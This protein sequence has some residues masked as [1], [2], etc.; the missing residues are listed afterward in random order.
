MR[1]TFAIAVATLLAPALAGCADELAPPMDGPPVAELGAGAERFEP[2]DPG[3]VIELVMGPQGGRHLQAHARIENLWPGSL[4]DAEDAPLVA[5]RVFDQAGLQWDL[6]H[7]ALPEMFV[8]DEDGRYTLPDSR[9]VFMHNEA[10][11]ALDGARVELR[12]E[13]EDMTGARATDSRWVILRAVD[14]P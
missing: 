7:R 8:E 3:E 4:P 1:G 10:A 9:T 2:L 11:A 13:I 14:P 6:G 5:F 12:V